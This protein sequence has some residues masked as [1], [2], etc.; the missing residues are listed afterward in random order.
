MGKPVRD[1]RLSLQ[2]LRVPEAFLLYPIL[3]R[4]ESAGWFVSR[5][6]SVE[7]YEIAQPV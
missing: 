4:L 3:L 5:W 1:F 6:E 7:P 2:A